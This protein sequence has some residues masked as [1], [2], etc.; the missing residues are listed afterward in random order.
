MMADSGS[1]SPENCLRWL[2]IWLPGSNR[3]YAVRRNEINNFSRPEPLFLVHSGHSTVGHRDLFEYQA[4][5]QGGWVVL[6][7]SGCAV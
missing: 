6:D 1:T 2:P 4:I 3:G 7:V 5:P